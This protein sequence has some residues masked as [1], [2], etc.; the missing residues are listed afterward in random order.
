MPTGKVR[1]YNVVKG[2]GFITGDDGSDVFLDAKALPA[3][4]E[5]PNKAAKVNYSMADGRKGP[6]ALSIEILDQ[7]QSIIQK[8]RKTP[9]QMIPIMEDAIKLIDSIN[10]GFRNSKWPKE[11]HAKQIAGI[12]RAIASD[13]EK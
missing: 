9:E 3:G 8:S 13:L 1:F 11:S 5:P 10:E 4:A 2:F 12:L 7:P 6:Y